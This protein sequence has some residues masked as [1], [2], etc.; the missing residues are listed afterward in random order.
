MTFPLFLS[1]PPK[2]YTLKDRYIVANFTSFA[3]DD[4]HSMVNE[5]TTANRSPW[6]NFN[7]GKKPTDL[8]YTSCQ[9]KEFLLK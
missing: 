1:C 4:P 5:E 3:N 2:G 8:R 6:M 7:S 9:E